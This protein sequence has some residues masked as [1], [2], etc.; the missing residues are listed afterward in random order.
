MKGSRVKT[1]DLTSLETNQTEGDG[2]K[3]I[4]G[5]GTILY[6]STGQTNNQPINPRTK[7]SVHIDAIIYQPDTQQYIIII[8]IIVIIVDYKKIHVN[9]I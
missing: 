2:P 9:H 6:L 8:I 3:L 7:S 4:V 1:S 5:I